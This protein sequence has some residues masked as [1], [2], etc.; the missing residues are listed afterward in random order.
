MRW[1]YRTVEYLDEQYHQG[2]VP[3]FIGWFIC[4][5]YDAMVGPGWRYLARERWEEIRE[6]VGK[7]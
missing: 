2:R 4:D 6:W 1:R 5:V 3:G 7:R